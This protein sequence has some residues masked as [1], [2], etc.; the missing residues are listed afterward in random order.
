MHNGAGARVIARTGRGHTRDEGAGTAVEDRQQSLPDLAGAGHAE[1]AGKR[2]D[3]VLAP[4][5]HRAAIF[6]AGGDWGGAGSR[7]PR[8]WGKA[9]VL[10]RS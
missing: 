2:N 1:V 7:G 4:A 6:R 3:R 8:P 10:D 9:R 5:P